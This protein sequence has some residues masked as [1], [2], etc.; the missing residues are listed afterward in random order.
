MSADLIA[1]ASSKDAVIDNKLEKATAQELRAKAADK[2]KLKLQQALQ[3]NGGN[4]T[5][6][7]DGRFSFRNINKQSSTGGAANDNNSE[8]DNIGVTGHSMASNNRN[9]KREEQDNNEVP[10]VE[11]LLQQRVLTAVTQGLDK[12]VQA[13]QLS[14]SILNR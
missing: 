13:I 11:P 14:H 3:N 8:T 12:L 4:S 5:K 7:F 9:K 6:F 2:K 1:T 10:E